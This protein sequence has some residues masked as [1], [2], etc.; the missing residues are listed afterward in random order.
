MDGT[1]TLTEPLHHRALAEVFKEY[2]IDYGLETHIARF[3]GSGSLNTFTKVFA[4]SGVKVSEEEIKKCISKKHSLYTKFIHEE[5]IPFVP[6]AKEF[7]E[8]IDKM[9]LKRIIATGNSD[10]DAVRFILRKFRL[11]EYFPQ[12]LSIKEVARGKPFPDVF[13]EAAQRLNLLPAECIVLEDSVNGVQ[14]ASSAGIRCIAFDTTT[15][16]EDLFAADAF[17]VVKNYFEITDDLLNGS[18]KMSSE[19]SRIIFKHQ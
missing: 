2:G 14:A 12:I 15:K 1:I 11:L 8:K 5:E 10:L 16:S 3:A 18:A 19:K 9:G 13:I 4:A 7:I 6:G 17:A